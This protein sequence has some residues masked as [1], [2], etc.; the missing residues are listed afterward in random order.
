MGHIPGH[1]D[2]LI[3]NFIFASWI[4]MIHLFFVYDPKRG[5]KNKIE[6]PLE[7]SVEATAMAS[8]IEPTGGASSALQRKPATGALAK[9]EQSS[10]VDMKTSKPFSNM[11]PFQSVDYLL[12]NHRNVS[13]QY[14]QKAKNTPAYLPPSSRFS[15]LTSCLLSA[16]SSYLLL[17]LLTNQPPLPSRYFA[18]RYDSLLRRF[19]EVDAMEL[20][21]RLVINFNLWVSTGLMI[22]YIHSIIAF[23][24]VAFGL[25][26]PQ[27]WPPLVGN[28][29]EEY[30]IR[31]HWGKFWHQIFQVPYV[32]VSGAFTETLLSYLPKDSSLRNSRG[33][34]ARYLTTFF[35]FEL[36]ML[37]H[38]VQPLGV[39]GGAAQFWSSCWFFPM[40]VLGMLFEDIIGRLWMRLVGNRTSKWQSLLE[41]IVGHMWLLTWSLWC[42]PPWVYP[43]LR[44]GEEGAMMPY[45]VVKMLRHEVKIR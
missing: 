33:P 6:G 10:P 13:S 28:F 26:E 2:G 34:F 32:A 8:G 20:W 17:D 21:C 37:A 35:V 23:I 45:S 1:F 30:S 27:D 22:T 40:Q 19:D 42:V 31:N 38:M 5:S 18:P 25:Y 15:F 12:I 36:S 9:N 14:F 29:A 39:T 44:R 41:R 11:T 7:N 16:G 24:G 4:R 43:S 3:A